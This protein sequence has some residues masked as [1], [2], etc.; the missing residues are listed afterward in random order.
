VQLTLRTEAGCKNEAYQREPVSICVYFV[1]Q[2]L[3]RFWRIS[4]QNRSSVSDDMSVTSVSFRS[5]GNERTYLSA[6]LRSRFMRPP[7]FLAKSL[8]GE[9]RTVCYCLKG[10]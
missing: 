6:N 1:S 3:V 8:G 4:Y 2:R 7:R 5:K 9:R 10:K